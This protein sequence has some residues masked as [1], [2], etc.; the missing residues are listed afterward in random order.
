MDYF[1]IF[2]TFKLNTLTNEYKSMARSCLSVET[3][4]E[5][6]RTG[7]DEIEPYLNRF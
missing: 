3:C 5:G 4:F 6:V 7:V 2:P 1:T